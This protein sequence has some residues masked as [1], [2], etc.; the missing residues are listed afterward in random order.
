MLFLADNENTI[1]NYFLNYLLRILCGDT[2]NEIFQWAQEGVGEELK[3][4][5]K[6]FSS[7]LNIEK[8][9]ETVFLGQICNIFEF[10]QNVL[11][12]RNGIKAVIK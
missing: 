4:C 2:R 10:P 1:L 3:L 12:Y 9:I 5:G 6:H 7:F 11:E 8:T